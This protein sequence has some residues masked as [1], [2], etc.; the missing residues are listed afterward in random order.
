MITAKQ[1]SKLRKHQY[2]MD[3]YKFYKRELNKISDELQKAVKHHK[4]RVSR[5]YRNLTRGEYDML[6]DICADY[7][8]VGYAV[9]IDDKGKNSKGVHIYQFF[10]EV[11]E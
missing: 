7:S 4:I 10:L 6:K 1:A 8:E 11:N 5:T 3:M 9:W 2:L